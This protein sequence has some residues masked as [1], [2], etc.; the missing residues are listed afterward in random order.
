M[1]RTPTYMPAVLVNLANNPR[2]GSSKEKRI[3]QAVILGLP[4]I[5]RVLET[6]KQ[7][8]LRLEADS[9][10]SLNFNK[11]AGVAKTNPAAL[12]GEYTIDSEGNVCI[13]TP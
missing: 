12:N 11:V 9:T 4:F 8:L 5:A 6:H 1:E 7:H 13:S 3:S 10:I 2:L